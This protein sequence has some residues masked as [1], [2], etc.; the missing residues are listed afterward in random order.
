MNNES[1][2]LD[3]RMLCDIKSRILTGISIIQNA[4]IPIVKSESGESDV[5]K[6]LESIKRWTC[7]PWNN[8]PCGDM[9]VVKEVISY[10]IPEASTTFALMDNDINDYHAECKIACKIMKYCNR[11]KELEEKLNGDPI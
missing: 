6:A 9:E 10:C 4:I 7:E 2:T 11:E 8:P 3:Y 5:S 1:F